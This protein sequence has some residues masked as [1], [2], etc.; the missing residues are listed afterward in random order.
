MH[1]EGL[2]LSSSLSLFLSHLSLLRTLSPPAQ[3]LVAQRV[4]ALINCSHCTEH[5][6]LCIHKSIDKLDVCARRVGIGRGMKEQGETGRA[7][8]RLGETEWDKVRQGETRG[9]Q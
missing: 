1:E 8:V 4:Y 3:V 5:S 7:S 2:S 6:A 9:A